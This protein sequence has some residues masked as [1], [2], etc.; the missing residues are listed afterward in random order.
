MMIDREHVF[1]LRNEAGGDVR[2]I[3]GAGEGETRETLT[4]E[5]R[6]RERRAKGKSGKRRNRRAIERVRRRRNMKEKR[7]ETKKV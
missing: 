4:E 7:G 6:P 5:N 1:G 2:Y 3:A